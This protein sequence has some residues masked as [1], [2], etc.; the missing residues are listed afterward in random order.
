MEHLNLPHPETHLAMI[1]G[2]ASRVPEGSVIVEVGAFAGVST[3]QFAIG[4]TV[5]AVDPWHWDS[6]TY[7]ERD[8]LMRDSA[9][10]GG[11][12]KVFQTFCRNAGDQLFKTIIP[13]RG[14]SDEVAE[15][16]PFLVDMVYVDGC[17]AKPCVKL[18]IETWWP[19]IKIGGILCGDD[20]GGFDVKE[21][22][23]SFFPNAEKPYHAQ[24]L[25]TKTG[26]NLTD[27]K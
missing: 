23:D 9:G 3:T 27:Y 13:I 22:V 10:I 18:D 12:R 11:G 26:E 4:R 16:F 1:R 17:H 25:V 20:Y 21:V 2:M 7:D 5:Y 24:W 6:P 14:Y 19:K 15:I 8:T